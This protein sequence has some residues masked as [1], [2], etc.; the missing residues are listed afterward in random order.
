MATAFWT[1][2]SNPNRNHKELTMPKTHRQAD[3]ADRRLL[4]AVLEKWHRPL[5]EAEV[6]F[7]LLYCSGGLSH[8]GY[9]CAATVKA[10]S[11]KDRV[12]GKPDATIVLNL[13]TWEQRSRSSKEAV[14]D[15][16]CQHC[17]VLMEVNANGETV[18]E[19]DDCGRPKL[20]MRKHDCFIGGF[21]V[22]I[23]RHG[24]EAIEAQQIH[25]AQRLIAD[26]FHV[27]E[28]KEKAVAG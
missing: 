24:P 15:H 13:D 10:N 9:P 22:I 7:G 8:G 27:I 19:L 25:D 23:E 1:A 26:L 12:D 11:Q 6:T 17:E 20:T 3:D 28:A 5:V 21:N 18:A 16:E 14:L 2:P 4:D